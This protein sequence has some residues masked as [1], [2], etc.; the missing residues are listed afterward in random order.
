MISDY[1]LPTSVTHFF[2]GVFNTEAGCFLIVF[3]EGFDE[4]DFV[5][6]TSPARVAVASAMRLLEFGLRDK[7]SFRCVNE[8]GAERCSGEGLFAPLVGM[9]TPRTSNRPSDVFTTSFVQRVLLGAGGDF[10]FAIRALS[11]SDRARA[12]PVRDRCTAVCKFACSAA[13]QDCTLSAR[14]DYTLDI[15]PAAP[16]DSCMSLQTLGSDWLKG[17]VKP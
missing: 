12:S 16:S 6:T 17:R 9:S 11:L 14:V 4:D 5:L 1:Q 13:A 7:P 2:L 10:K 15:A 3:W 8:D